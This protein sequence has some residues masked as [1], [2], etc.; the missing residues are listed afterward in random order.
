MTVKPNIP[1]AEALELTALISHTDGG[2]A[3]RVMARAGGGSATLFAFD[4]GQELSEHTAPYDALVIVLE[5]TL[6]L[7]I[8][9][10]SVRAGSGTVVRIPANAPHAVKSHDRS[11]MLLVML[12]GRD[13]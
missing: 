13:T 4:V 7:K 11:K 6:V 12:R 5:G 10:T 3:S 1:A 9:K 8:G 2:I